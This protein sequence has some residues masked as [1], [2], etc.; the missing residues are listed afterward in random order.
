MD[1]L[2]TGRLA[3][4]GSN[5]GKNYTFIDLFKFHFNPDYQGKPLLLTSDP[6]FSKEYTEFGSTWRS[7]CLLDDRLFLTCCK[8]TIALYDSSNGDQV[9]ERKFKGV[10]WCMTT[11]DNLVYVGLRSKE[12]IVLD[13]REL[14]INK[15]II[16]KGLGVGDC[17]CDITVS[18]NK[19]FI[20]TSYRKASMYNSEGEREQE[21]KNTQYIQARS[22]TVSEENGLIFILWADAGSSRQV[23]VYFP[24]GGHSSI[25]GGHSS[26]S[27]G[28]APISGGHMLAS[29]KVPDNSRRIRINNSINRLFLVTQTTGEVY[30]YHTS[31]IFTFDILL[32]CSESLI[33]KH[34]CQKLLDYFEVPAKESKDIIESDAPFF[35]AIH[36]LREAGKVSVDDISHLMRACSDKGLSKLVAVLT[37]YQQGQ[38]LN[39]D[40]LKALEGKRQELSHQLTESE[41]DK[42]QLTGRLKTSKEELKD[43]KSSLRAT[44][45]ELVKSQ[46]EH[47]KESMALQEVL[48]LPRE[49]LKQVEFVK[50]L[51]HFPSSCDILEQFL[52]QGDP[53]ASMT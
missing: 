27:G 14:S 42:Q 47:A 52:A 22:I 37:V 53:A 31:D 28:H 36:H 2:D 3:V 41:D 34:D 23:V 4:A 33:E 10:A 26:I 29:L 45:D 48:K 35:S 8:K 40:Q 7:V 6:Y 30:E 5:H 44:K 12:V 38:V 19:L 18:N 9:K 1:V 46:L 49:A 16:L 20:C 43:A 17:P 21:Y 24:S 39:K 32:M 25:S 51:S 15:T 11:R 13:A 50:P